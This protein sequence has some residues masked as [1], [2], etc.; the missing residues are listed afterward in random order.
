[1]FQRTSKIPILKKNNTSKKSSDNKSKNQ[2]AAQSTSKKSQSNKA[3]SQRS[4]TD[5]KLTSLDVLNEFYLPRHNSGDHLV[6]DFLLK[7]ISATPTLAYYFP[8]IIHSNPTFSTGTTNTTKKRLTFLN[9][10]QKESNEIYFNRKIYANNLASTKSGLFNNFDSSF[11]LELSEDDSFLNADLLSTDLISSNRNENFFYDFNSIDQ[12][13][14]NHG[15]NLDKLLL[16]DFRKKLS[17]I[18][19]ESSGRSSLISRTKWSSSISQVSNEAN[20]NTPTN[21]NQ[22]SSNSNNKKL[23][24]NGTVASSTSNTTKIINNNKADVFGRPM[25][26]HLNRTYIKN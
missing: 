4:K 8:E 11:D 17:Q 1:M 2:Q 3:G 18:N 7:N 24:K 22:N 5:D 10:N 25:H 21:F 9:P 26:R 20:N 13:K 6:S 12:H 19:E 15:F 14:D 16:E 23:L